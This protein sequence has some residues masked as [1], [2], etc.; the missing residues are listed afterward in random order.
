MLIFLICV[1]TLIFGIVFAILSDNW[2]EIKNER[3]RDFLSNISCAFDFL[4]VSG[5]VIGLLSTLICVLFLIGNNINPELKYRKDEITYEILQEQV[6]N[7]DY[8]STT[9]TSDIIEYNQKVT[10]YKDKYD[11]PWVGWFYYKDCE[12]LPFV[13]IRE[14]QK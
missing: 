7:G 5:V 2:Y 14:T 6:D 8:N 1:A 12:K 13:E 11:S 4:S 10:E 3:L 9:L